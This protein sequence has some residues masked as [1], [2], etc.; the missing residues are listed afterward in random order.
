MLYRR[1]L[2]IAPENDHLLENYRRLSVERSP[3]GLYAFAGPGKVALS[4][5]RVCGFWRR[6]AARLVD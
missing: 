6:L 2:D 1:G 4:R 5:S 3:D